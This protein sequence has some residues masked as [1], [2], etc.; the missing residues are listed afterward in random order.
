MKDRMFQ[1]G[2]ALTLLSLTLAACG[3]QTAP[4]AQQSGTTPA[5]L[6]STLSVP[7]A[8][9]DNETPQLWFVEFQGK[10][11]SKGGNRAAIAQE[12]HPMETSHRGHRGQGRP[13]T[14]GRIVELHRAE[15]HGMSR[16]RS[17][18]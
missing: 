8:Q 11:T 13:A 7:T 17:P 1:R 3:T 6:L 14:R 10:P 5:P 4:V 18:G 15:R 12:R 2:A 16:L 9:T